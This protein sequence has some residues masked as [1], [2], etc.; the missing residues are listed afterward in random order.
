MDRISA[1]ADIGRIVNVDIARQQ[2]EGGIIWGLATALG[3][4]MSYDKG[5]AMANNLAALHLPVL[6]NSP[7]IITHLIASPHQ[8]GGVGEIA[9]PPVAPA[10]PN[11]L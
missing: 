3:N 10:I 7:E 11:A 4:A 9:V 2:I 5:K 6:A 1:V 8:S